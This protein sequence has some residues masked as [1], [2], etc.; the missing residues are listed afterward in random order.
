VSEHKKPTTGRLVKLLHHTRL[1]RGM[2]LIPETSRCIRRYD[3]HELVVTDQRD[4]VAGSRIDRV[5]FLGF[6]EFSR[7]GV[8]EVGDELWVD[9]RVVGRVI[10]FDGCHLPNHYNILVHAAALTNGADLQ[11]RIGDA[12]AF[13]PPYPTAI[14]APP[15]VIAG[16]GRA[17]K[18]LH[19]PCIR[20]ARQLAFG[21]DA[22]EQVFVF[23][24][25]LDPSSEDRE[26]LR[27][28]TWVE[29]L[30]AIP[31]PA[32]E[33]AVVHVCTP[34]HVRSELVAAA[35]K[36]GLRRFVL[37]KPM[38]NSPKELESL[39]DLRRRYELDILVVSNW[40]A[41]NLT[42]AIK[43]RLRDRPGIEI[44]RVTMH[45]HKSRIMR[46]RENSS[47]ET[48]FDVE[49]PHMLGLAFVFCGPEMHVRESVSWDLA[50]DGTRI[51]DMG[52]TSITLES[53]RGQVIVL[54]TDHMS[55]LRQRSIV[56]ELSNG[57]RYE[58]YFPCTSADLYSQLLT[59]DPAG[60]LLEREFIK[61]DTLTRFFIEAYQWF[62]GSGPRP[63]SDF[64]FNVGVCSML[65]EA[66]RR[67]VSTPGSAGILPRSPL[68]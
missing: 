24:P 25:L 36:L 41:S 5:G 27:H 58:G 15:T 35:A 64:D 63:H 66:K 65:L 60:A 1:D 6:A 3:L 55:P 11:L 50:V 48:A 28:C 54:H 53:A 26:A 32:R 17:G 67:S 51:Q 13:Q 9:G 47:H 44:T 4:C 62:A 33:H 56:I 31:R 19:L 42:A 52:G 34:P 57:A 38:A 12:I 10:G 29:E 46:S 8:V 18:A 21:Q 49:V 14:T 43:Q 68:S 20:H 2:T 23:D 37:E 39:S 59:Y 30:A 61:D 22:S 45:Q 16:F 7:A 40:V